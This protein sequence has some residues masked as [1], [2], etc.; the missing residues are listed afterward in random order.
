MKV[1]KHNI[2]HNF[3]FYGDPVMV[4]LNVLPALMESAQRGTKNNLK[5]LVIA[6]AIPDQWGEHLN[7]AI[8]G[9]GEI[10]KGVTSV[11]DVNHQLKPFGNFY[12]N[13]CDEGRGM[14]RIPKSEYEFW[15]FFDTPFGE[16]GTF[17]LR[18]NK[19]LLQRHCIKNYV[20][21][22]ATAQEFPDTFRRVTLV[23]DLQNKH[24]LDKLLLQMICPRATANA[25]P[26]ETNQSERR[27]ALQVIV[28]F[29][30]FVPEK[31]FF[32]AFVRIKDQQEAKSDSASSIKYS[33]SAD[34]VTT[35][36]LS[37]TWRTS[38]E[39][40]IPIIDILFIQKCDELDLHTLFG[41]VITMDIRLHYAGFVAILK[42]PTNIL[43]KK[44]ILRVILTNQ[45]DLI[46]LYGNNKQGNTGLEKLSTDTPRGCANTVD[47]FS[48]SLRE[49]QDLI[50][51]LL[52]LT[53]V[54]L[55]APVFNTVMTGV[56]KD[57]NLDEKDIEELL[58]LQD[59]TTQCV[60]ELA[61]S[62]NL[63]EATVTRLIKSAITKSTGGL[64][65]YP[66]EEKR[67]TSSWLVS[68]AEGLTGKRETH[69]DV[70]PLSV[71]SPNYGLRQLMETFRSDFCR[72]LYSTASA[73]NIISELYSSSL[74]PTSMLISALI[75]SHLQTVDYLAKSN[76]SNRD[77]YIAIAT[78]TIAVGLGALVHLIPPIAIASSI[79]M[80]IVAGHRA[81]VDSTRHEKEL[82]VLSEDDCDLQGIMIF[83]R[84]GGPPYDENVYMAKLKFLLK[85]AG[86]THPFTDIPAME[87]EVWQWLKESRG[88]T[89][90]CEKCTT[91]SQTADK[92]VDKRV[93]NVLKEVDTI[94]QGQSDNIRASRMAFL[95]WVQSVGLIGRIRS[96]YNTSFTIGIVG[97]SRDGK[98]SH[99][100]TVVGLCNYTNRYMHKTKKSLRQID[101]T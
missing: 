72:Q 26:L 29:P 38:V 48:K 14:M 93:E 86:E 40:M 67:T 56:R 55:L 83:P 79:V 52:G 68:A 62:P 101:F 39:I 45:S 94:F 1:S 61:Y 88:Q 10:F 18:L 49:T 15:E 21:I 60:R 80:L 5:Q 33:K 76:T 82:A 63:T 20:D 32:D 89:F 12:F 59:E 8:T 51:E 92:P 95:R 81:H 47:E 36:S 85:M 98:F 96:I 91:D 84:I 46:M 2:F 7:D 19:S 13:K 11:S 53:R 4:L 73:D 57:T 71:Q 24:H 16:P 90:I 42:D 31:L 64:D 9:F 97:I 100:Y 78:G 22:F 25:F 74:N 65:Q 50:D 35:A 6:A 30:A 17:H 69:I 3:A 66:V 54:D 99:I 70:T 37:M 75:L 87:L 34:A 27:M 58:A 41:D 77:L 28:D 23:P 44:Q 43:L